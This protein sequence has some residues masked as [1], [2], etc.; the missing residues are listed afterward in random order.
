M[1]TTPQEDVVIVGGGPAGS[2]CAC[3]LASKGL[4]PLVLE[5]ESEPRHKICGE[6]ISIEA[7][8]ILAALGVDLQSLGGALIGTVRLV[9]EHEIVETT[10]PFEGIGLTRRALDEALLRQA[11]A[12]GARV[13]RGVVVGGIVPNESGFDIGLRDEP[14]MQAGTVFLATGKHDLRSLK[15]SS[16]G[17]GEDLIG[18]KTYWRMAPSQRTAL[19]HAVEVVLFKGGY[20]GLQCVEG[21]LANLCLLVRRPVFEAAGRTWEKLLDQLLRGSPHLRRRL[22]GAEPTLPRPLTIAN[23]PYGF[24]HRSDA[25]ETQ[26]LFRLGDQMGVIP[27]FCGDGVAMA[28]HTA[29]LAAL[30]Y[31]E[32]G[33]VASAY[34]ALARADIGRPITIASMLYNFGSMRFGRSALMAVSR[35]YPG[36][37]QTI[38][39]LTRI[40]PSAAL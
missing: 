1:R 31:A 11:E 8:G 2:A 27:S 29:R 28:L 19:E 35:L 30:T 17:S 4:S 6:F 36:I 14:S 32:H 15:R 13:R 40:R 26:G 37:L 7:Q 25:D 34:H 3:V 9:F 39:S 21:G 18:F 23:V 10:L 20:A 5:R 16:G 24:V 33:R 38:A 12:S 22:F